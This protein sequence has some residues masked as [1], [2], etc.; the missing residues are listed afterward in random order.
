MVKLILYILIVE[1][2]IPQ[3][4]FPVNEWVII[5]GKINFFNKKYQITNP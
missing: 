3:K 4:T 5:S 2:D 1:K